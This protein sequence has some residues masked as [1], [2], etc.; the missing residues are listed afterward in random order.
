[1][2][3]SGKKALVTGAAGGIGQIICALLRAEGARVAAAD[4]DCLAIEAEAILSGDLREQAYADGLPRAAADALGGL[5]IIINNAGVIT[6]GPITET[7][8][9]DLALSLGVNVEAPFRICR[10]SIPILADAGGGAIVNT[11][12]CWGVH[13][14]PNHAVYCMTKAAVASLTQCMGRDHAHQNIRI[15]AVC[16][17]EVDTPM[18]RTGF[19][20]RGF[21]PET[22]IEELGKTVPLGRVATAQDIAE[23][24]LFLA[25]DAARYMCGALVEV[26][27]GKPVG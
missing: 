11:A 14:G 1:M 15:N 3:F 19:Q 16:P 22:A 7:S 6:R 20:K 27:G 2:R 18:L 24:V 10:A 21:D 8:D 4:R 13:P 12:S 9:A 26:N 17:N 25:S 23:V 5:D